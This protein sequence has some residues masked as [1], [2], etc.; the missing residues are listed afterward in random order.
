MFASCSNLQSLDV[1]NFD[2]SNVTMMSVMFGTVTMNGEIM[3]ITEIKGLENFKTNK[4]TDM[5]GMFANCIKLKDIDISNFDTENLKGAEFMFLN[6]RNITKLNL[7]NFRTDNAVYIDG[8]FAGCSTLKEIDLSS[9]N[10]S[11][12]QNTYNMFN[13]CTN[14]ETIY[15]S[16]Y[17]EATDTGWTTKNV[18]NSEYMFTNCTSLVGGIGTTFDPSHIDKEY[19]RIDKAGEPGYLTKQIKN[20]TLMQVDENSQ[21]YFNSGIDKTEI[22][23]ITFAKGDVPT[24][25]IISQFDASVEQDKNIIGYYT[26]KDGDNLYELTFVTNGTIYTNENSANL[27]KGLT[28]LT[29][30]TFDNINTEKTTNMKSMFASCVDLQSIDLSNFNTINVTTMDLMFIGCSKLEKIKFGDKFSTQNVTNMS[31]M[32]QACS[33]LTSLDLTEFNT[34]NVTN[35]SYM[36]YNCRELTTIDLSSF[37]TSKVTNMRN[38][39]YN[40]GGLTTIYA[41]EYN[42]ATDTGWSTKSVTNSIYMFNNNLV[43]VGGNGTKFDSS[44]IDKEYARIDKAGEP[45]Y[46]TNITDKQ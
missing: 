35:M 21:T 42:E 46:F 4:V 7:K 22:E 20:G 9:F 32:F 17:D 15:V 39:F 14:L 38:M 29:T 2:T 43:L 41:S 12:V 8:L 24:S 40:C 19:A 16:E 6:C 44:H 5:G 1:S 23:T 3:S 30:I 25:G 10:T 31:Y 36:F 33:V 26:D 34:S 45:G 27:F 28:K 13:G 18:T 11:K 37:N